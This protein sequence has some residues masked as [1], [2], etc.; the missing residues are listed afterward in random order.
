MT[1]PRRGV[2]AY[3]LRALLQGETEGGMS[4]QRPVRS[5]AFLEIV[6][7]AALWAVLLFAMV[8]ALWFVLSSMFSWQI[9]QILGIFG[10]A[11][12]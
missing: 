2:G 6:V 5:G 1:G 11:S 9:G 10:V 7:I 8:A 3:A 4:I 12:G